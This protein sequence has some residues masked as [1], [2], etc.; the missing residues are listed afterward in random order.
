MQCVQ[1]NKY[2]YGGAYFVEAV[3]KLP[4]AKQLSSGVIVQLLQ[5]AINAMGDNYTKQLCSVP[6]AAG[7][8]GADATSLVCAA[9]M[10][11]NAGV[12]QRIT[13]DLV[14]LPAIAQLDSTE[15]RQLLQ[16]A[17]SHSAPDRS[18]WHPGLRFLCGLPAAQQLSSA[19][20]EQLLQA[21]AARKS[22][23]SISSFLTLPA[24]EQLSSAAV[25]QLLQAA[26]D[27]K[28]SNIIE[29][30][31]S[32][33]AAA[34]LGIEHAASLLAA[35]VGAE[36][37]PS[38]Y[39]LTT[40]PAAAALG[41]EHAAS[42][43]EAAVQPSIPV[44]ATDVSHMV[45]ALKML[46]GT[47]SLDGGQLTR[48]FQAAAL[49]CPAACITELCKLPSAYQLNADQL[50]QALDAAVQRGSVASI[51]LLVKTPAAKQLSSEAAEALLQTAQQLNTA[52]R[53][54]V[55]APLRKLLNAARKRQL[56][57]QQAN[58]NEG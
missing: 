31:A 6:E 28:Q 51:K 46:P 29:K 47:E 53:A 52:R 11:A 40:L 2:V 27:I 26:V 36:Y 32:L 14:R 24:K 21:A 54:K 37:S 38:V 49:R 10:I 19:E 43:L 57:L 5:A 17:A 44:D 45:R 1:H 16:V 18:P 13:S 50:A 20:V 7:I 12:S 4:G 9:F 3:C 42:L 56:L 8:S 48:V 39:A 23:A 41:S 25:A 58:V 55:S 15:I 30:L 22:S 33:P 35:A 34:L